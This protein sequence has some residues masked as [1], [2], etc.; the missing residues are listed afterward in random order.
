MRYSIATFRASALLILVGLVIPMTS[1]QVIID[2]NKGDHREWK[3]GYMDGNLVGTVYHNHGQVAD[4]QYFPSLSG[5]WPKGTNHTYVDGVAM[6]VQAEAHVPD[7][8]NPANT[9]TFHPLET[10][11][12]EYLR[13]DR[14][15][16]VTYGWWPIPGYSARF[17]TSPAVS[18]DAATW[19]PHWPDRTTDWD[20]YWN[21]YFGKGI[22]NA[23]LETYF[24]Y[25][26]NEDREYVLRYNYRPDETDTT[27]G[28]LGMQ[29]R[30]RGF[31]WSQ[32]LAEDVIFWHY[33]ITNMSTTDY[34]KTLFAEYVDWGIGG[35]DNSSNNA[36]D[37]D[38][39]LNISYAW[40]TV[41]RGNPGNWSPVGVTGYAFLESPGIS[42]DDRDNDLDGLTDERREN[43]A[44]VYVTNP[45]A[46]PFLRDAIKDTAQ[47]RVFYGRSWA[48]HWDADENCNWRS[49]GDL[50]M[51]GKWDTGEPL[52]DDVGTDG[53]GPFDA[54][55]T[56]PDPDGT[57]GNGKPDQGEPDFGILDKD[58]S[59]Q[60]GLTGFLISAV[61]EPQDLNNDEANWKT[62]SALPPPHGGQLVGVNLANRFSSYL[63]PMAGS[64]TLGG[65]VG[66]SE[67]F[68]MALIYG[69]DIGDLIRRKQTVQQI[70]NAGYR[71]AKPPE[72]PLVKAIAGDRRVTL[73]WDS[74][75]ENTF[76]AFYQ[77]INFEGYRVYRATDANFLESKIITDAYGKSTYRQPIAQFDLVDGVKGLSSIDVNGALFYLGNDTGLEHSF[78]DSTVQNGQTYYYAVVSYDR[79]FTT[80]TVQGDFLGIP[81]SECTSIIKVDINGQARTDV[82]TAVLTP[83]APAAGYTSPDFQLMTA[84]GPGT[85][86]ISGQILDPDSLRNGH[87][88]KL[89]FIDST[90]FRN[91]P[92]PFYFLVDLTTGDTLIK[93]I[94]M[95]SSQV[96]T[97]VIDGFSL[98]VQND[99]MVSIDPSTTGWVQKNT[100]FVT[101][102]GFNSDLGTALAVRRVDYPADF[103][104]RFTAPGAGVLAM[105]RSTFSQPNP[106]NVIIK[107]VT[108][109]RDSIQL[110][111]FDNNNNE[112][113]DPGEAVF[114]AVGDSLGKPAA[115]FSRA[116]FTWS[117]ALKKDTTIAEANQRPPQPGDVFRITTRKPFRNGEYFGFQ[118]TAPRYDVKK[119]Q[120]NLNKVTVVPNP[121]AGA[122]TWEPA[123][124]SVGRGERRIFF[125]HLPATCTIRIYTIAGRLVQTLEHVA[126]IDDGQEAWNLVS[127]DGMDIAYGVY[128]FHVDAPGLGTTVGKFAVL[129]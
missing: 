50:N 20:G 83:H 82:N 14:S 22:Q 89:G 19:P 67:R 62:F 64:K 35:H 7:P 12:Y 26:D 45:A 87:G 15:T 29:V 98:K 48:P 114:I 72:K 21:G 30:A 10:N 100:T 34:P 86:T 37:Y 24:V 122:A 51:N 42:N 118:S 93:P 76:D 107:N 99:P 117:L 6:I 9:L 44:S 94:R 101:E 1:A 47:F 31:Q 75:A 36:G 49:F 109:N 78:V 41:S 115:S 32:V 124:T 79:G 38:K 111:F 116:K 57:E 97:P 71:F 66:H 95:I 96:V 102:A 28:G 4:W 8:A 119:A 123:T 113:L 106:S 77:R 61:H 60:L 11:Y 70:Y 18:N 23:D 17:Q 108:E 59:D 73:Y 85:G 88:Y 126:G 55:Y 127:R 25:D 43:T 74:R 91:D 112:Q 105:P 27:R 63:F 125:T 121:Y 110:V 104:I 65:E 80:T 103:E 16:G 46:D 56:G 128:V 129:K 52:N 120:A 5:V 13:Y 68:S 3:H 40:S 69:M 92:S 58:E 90:A 33:E 54:G 2:R 39:L 81:P 53:I 84:T